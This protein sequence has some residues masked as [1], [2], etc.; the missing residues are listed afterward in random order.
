MKS[1]N[2]NVISIVFVVIVASVATVFLVGLNYNTFANA[3]NAIPNTSNNA[4]NNLPNISAQGIYEQKSAVLGNDVHNFVVLIPNEA[5]EST[6]QPKN[7]YPFLNQAYLP[8]DIT[9]NKGTSITWFNGDADHDHIVKFQT[10]NSANLESTDEFPFTEF[11]TVTFNQT[12]KY[13]Y[14]EDEVNENDPDFV[15]RGT[16]NVVDISATT[17]INNVNMPTPTNT[18]GILMVPSK[19]AQTISSTLKDNAISNLGDYTFTDLRGGQE[20]TGPTQTITIWGTENDNI[21]QVMSSIKGVTE[22]LPYS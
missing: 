21:N 3:Q 9:I 2:N 1:N 11:A 8:Q 19:D 6:N 15:M 4:N 7:Q 16:V 17:K 20:G 14:F 12:G 18:M 5:H 22:E 13:S 10:P